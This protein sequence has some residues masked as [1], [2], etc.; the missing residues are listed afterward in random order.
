[1]T[2]PLD[3]CSRALGHLSAARL[4]LCD[5]DDQI[6]A[7]HICNAHDA[8]GELWMLMRSDVTPAA[9]RHIE[10]L[11]TRDHEQATPRNDSDVGALGR[12][13]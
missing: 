1:M 13:G 4:Q 11:R 9:E 10:V 8:V 7:G 12:T 6:I 2:T 3:L 5:A